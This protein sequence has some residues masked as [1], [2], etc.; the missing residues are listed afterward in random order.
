[1]TTDKQRQ[2]NQQNAQKSTGPK[3]PEGKAK[4]AQNARK[5]PSYIGAGALNEEESELLAELL[6]LLKAELQPSDL[7]EDQLVEKIAINHLK[8]VRARKMEEE[9]LKLFPRVELIERLPRSV[10][11][12]D[13]QERLSHALQRFSK[14]EQSYWKTRR[15]L[16]HYRAQ[17]AY[18][19]TQRL[20]QGLLAEK[21]I[22]AQQKNRIRALQIQQL[23][24]NLKN[25]K[26]N[27]MSSLP[28]PPKPP[29]G[30][31]F[32]LRWVSS[33]ESH[34]QTSPDPPQK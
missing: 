10:Q 29:Q 8:M 18:Q 30:E 19:Q 2:A 3:T 14:A 17:K 15:E 21:I 23:E 25:S 13:D 33:A 27:P 16:D 31:N 20:R 28:I 24:K 32:T 4:S 6:S 26:T 34:P 5:Y 1:M 9:A 12:L 22:E 11:E 7:L